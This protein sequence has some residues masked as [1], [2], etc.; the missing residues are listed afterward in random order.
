MSFR[1]LAQAHS[2]N[3]LPSI[4]KR[5]M[6]STLAVFINRLMENGSSSLVFVMEAYMS[7]ILPIR[8][9]TS[10][11][12]VTRAT[13]AYFSS[14]PSDVC[15]WVVVGIHVLSSGPLM[16]LSH[17]VATMWVI[18]LFYFWYSKISLFKKRHE[19]IGHDHSVWAL[20]TLPSEPMA[21]LT[22]SADRT[23]KLHDVN[24]NAIRTFI[25]RGIPK[26]KIIDSSQ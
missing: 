5:A 14:M 12:K 19:L 26:L 3:P 8:N 17:I 10:S 22:G 20:A 15:S 9:P 6:P 21:Y 11:S 23:L 7:I 24:A 18:S 25:G 16:R 4:L 13:F 2:S 1:S